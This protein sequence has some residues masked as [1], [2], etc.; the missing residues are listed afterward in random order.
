MD[1]LL[2]QQQQ[3]MQHVEII[4]A[5]VRNISHTLGLHINMD[6]LS[7]I[8]GLHPQ[9]YT[10]SPRPL[11]PANVSPSPASACP[12]IPTPTPCTLIQSVTPANQRPVS[13]SP[14]VEKSNQKVLPPSEVVTKSP[15]LWGDCKIE[16]LAAKLARESFFGK[17]LMHQSTVMGF[18]DFPALPVDGIQAL[19]QTILSVCPEHQQNPHGFESAWRRCIRVDAINHACSKR[20]K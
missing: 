8:P 14:S 4:N 1:E 5:R 6:Q 9:P 13:K 10:S 7:S 12:S 3:I 11:T 15:P 2:H 19:K 20:R 16:E 17:E 18:K